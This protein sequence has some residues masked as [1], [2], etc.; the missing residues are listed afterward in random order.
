MTNNIRRLRLERGLTQSELGKKLGVTKGAV[1]TWENGKR[2]PSAAAVEK[3]CGFFSITRAELY[4][5]EAEIV[6][7]KTVSGISREET[8]RFI[9]ENERLCLWAALLSA[10]DNAE[11]CLF[12]AAEEIMEKRNDVKAPFKDEYIEEEQYHA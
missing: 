1:Y 11:K 9:H 4:M 8:L 3:M 5:S 6:E 2:E 10:T 7:K 12:S